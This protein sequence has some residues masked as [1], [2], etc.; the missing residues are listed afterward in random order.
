[1][2]FALLLGAALFLA[3]CGQQGTLG[4]ALGQMRSLLA[5]GETEVQGFTATRASLAEAGITA[6]IM[7][8]RLPELEASAGFLRYQENR[9]VTVWRSLDGSLISTSG[10]VLLSTRGVGTDLHSIETAPVEQALAHGGDAHYSRLYRQLDGEGR[11]RA[12]RFYCQ[13]TAMGAEQVA[14]LGRSYST[15]RMVETCRSPDDAAHVTLQNTYWR[16][17]N[18]RIWKSRQWAGPQLGYAELEHVVN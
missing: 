15:Q 12:I 4:V 2:R 11:I 14:V 9:G 10:G 3:A 6:P 16:G 5:S 13:L 17:A 7:V 1:M 8:L 18:G